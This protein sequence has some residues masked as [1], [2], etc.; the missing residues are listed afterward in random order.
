MSFDAL[1]PFYR[2]LEYALAG[3]L[4]QRCR[5]AF[6]QEAST[7]RQALILGEGP[8]RFLEALLRCH[9]QVQVTCVE[10]SAPM[11][12]ACRRRLESAGLDCSRV[13]FEIC[14][15][16]EWVPAGV[17]YDLIA[18]H[19]F[20]DCFTPEQ[21]REIV[22]KIGRQASPSSRWLLSDFCVPSGGW[23]R[24]RARVIL[25]LMYAVFRRLTR[26]EASK[27]TPPDPY[28]AAEGFQLRGRRHFS[29][30]LM[31]ADFWERVAA[32]GEG[33]G[34]VASQGRSVEN[35]GQ[36]YEICLRTGDG[37]TE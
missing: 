1:A 17:S 35:V 11:V 31:H 3:R 4:M 30:G 14:D 26:I 28:L 29:Q 16:L 20:L 27:I 13:R 12:K 9:P 10:R 18:C 7:C 19:F 2:G 5:T 32:V 25:S 8:G 23:Q 36:R 21:I 6:L 15:V 24:G 37:T 33:E 34:K 22:G